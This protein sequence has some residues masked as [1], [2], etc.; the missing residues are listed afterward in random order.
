MPTTC[1]LRHIRSVDKITIYD[2]PEYSSMIT[3][4]FTIKSGNY[5]ARGIYHG[6]TESTEKYR[7]FPMFLW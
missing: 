3:F 1:N 7:R 2:K 4:L 6:D 5:S